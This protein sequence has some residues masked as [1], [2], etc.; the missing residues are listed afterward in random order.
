MVYRRR[1]IYVVSSEG[2]TEISWVRF[3]P[4]FAYSCHGRETRATSGGRMREEEG[5]IKGETQIQEEF[6]R[7]AG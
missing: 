4:A 6:Q 3:K 5:M 2:R 1:E 7:E